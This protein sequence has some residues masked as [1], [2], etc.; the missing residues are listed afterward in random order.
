MEEREE[1]KIL[2]PARPKTARDSR[3]YIQD[4]RQHH[5]ALCRKL[6]ASGQEVGEKDIPFDGLSN[7]QIVKILLGDTKGM[8]EEAIRKK[9]REEIRRWHPDKFS[10]KIGGRIETK[11]VNTIMERVKR[12]SQA[13]N[14]FR[15]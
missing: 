6:F 3:S 5:R 15:Q 2:V 9:V 4:G 7:S 1:P 8:N 10:Q 14:D 11:D 12:V 13:L